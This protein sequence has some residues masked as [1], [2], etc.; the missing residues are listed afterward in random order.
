MSD[1]PTKLEP[2]RLR[3]EGKAGIEGFILFLP[4]RL[5]KLT[6]D[7]LLEFVE[8]IETIEEEIKEVYYDIGAD[9]ARG[10]ESW[11]FRIHSILLNEV[12]ARRVIHRLQ[13][14]GIVSQE[15]G[16]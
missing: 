4:S 5:E 7:Q 13:D 9:S 15:G 2:I 12:D 6:D 16:L 1:Q 3:H 8:K 10:Q 11:V 14:R